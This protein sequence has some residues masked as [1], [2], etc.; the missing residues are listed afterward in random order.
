M[1]L[2]VSVGDNKV[3]HEPLLV[4][5]ATKNHCWLQKPPLLL[6]SCVCCQG[7]GCRSCHVL[8]LLPGSGLQV[9]SCVVFVARV[10]GTGRHL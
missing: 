6:L 5:E 4:V 7:R 3:V 2:N 8:C 10:W 1:T 9:M